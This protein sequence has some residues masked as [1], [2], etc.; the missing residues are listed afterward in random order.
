V[1]LKQEN[2]PTKLLTEGGDRVN[3]FDEGMT[4]GEAGAKGASGSSVSAAAQKSLLSSKWAKGGK[5]LS[6]LVKWTDR[7]AK[8]GTVT[9][10][11]ASTGSEAAESDPV[12]TY[13]VMKGAVDAGFAYGS[14]YYG[15]G[16]VASFALEVTPVGNGLTAKERGIRFLTRR[17]LEAQVDQ[18]VSQ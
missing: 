16:A 15:A 7:F 5:T 6:N 3:V 2:G 9:S 4:E 8:G 12:G 1:L 14:Y 13:E 18:V 17:I 10:L 11:L